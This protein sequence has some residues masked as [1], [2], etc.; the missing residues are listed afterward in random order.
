MWSRDTIFRLTVK[1]LYRH[2]QIWTP[3]S[4]MEIGD[5][6]ENLNLSLDYGTTGRRIMPRVRTFTGIVVKLGR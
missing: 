6:M 2:S 3:L 4:T 1:S 5:D